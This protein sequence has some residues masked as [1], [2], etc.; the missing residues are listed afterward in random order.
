MRKIPK[1]FRSTFEYLNSFVAPLIEETHSDMLSSMTRVSRLPS[2]EI[3]SVERDKEHYRPPRDLFYKIVLRNMLRSDSNQGDN[4]LVPYRP[5]T[6]DIVALT[7]VRPNS[8]SDLNRPRI[9][10]LL[11][12]VHAADYDNP[13]LLSIVLSKPIMNIDQE[14]QRKDDQNTLF[15][16]FLINMTTNI[17]IWKALHPDPIGGNLKMINKIVQTDGSVRIFISFLTL[18]LFLFW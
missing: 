8:I 18:K 12:Y 3:Y 9:S 4:S 16:V 7:D 17:R 5:Q 1:T 11:A 2:C 10:F 13:N 6:G 15:L 14:M